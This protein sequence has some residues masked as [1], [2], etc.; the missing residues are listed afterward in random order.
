MLSEL[1]KRKH[2]STDAHPAVGFSDLD[3]QI[4]KRILLMSFI[5]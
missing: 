1:S 5:F 2:Y 4:L 3:G